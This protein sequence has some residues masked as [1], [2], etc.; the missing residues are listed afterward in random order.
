MV[1]MLADVV[2][3]GTAWP[4]RREGFM[5]PA[6]GKTGTTNDYH[7]AWFIGFT[8]HLTTGVWVG[9]DQPRTIIGRGYAAELAV[10]LWARFMKEATRGDKPEWFSRPRSITTARICRLSGKLATDACH[11]DGP[12]R[13]S[14]AYYE[15]FVAGTEPTDSC[16]LH[17]P[18]LSRPFRALAALIMPKS[19]P[20]AHGTAPAPPPPAV[21]SEAPAPKAEAQPA[22]KKRGFW[23]RVFGVGKDDKD[24]RKR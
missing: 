18:V 12:E 8:P 22:P 2:N 11:D 13:R 14:T 9:Y 24:D 17:N 15:N 10:P 6:A 7:D 19:A 4:A 16:P 23:S 1:E 21:V 3:S 20:T 5:A